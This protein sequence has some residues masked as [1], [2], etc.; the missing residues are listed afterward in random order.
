[1][2]GAKQIVPG[3][4]IA[5][6]RGGAQESQRGVPR[7]SGQRTSQRYSLANFRVARPTTI[8]NTRY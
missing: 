4:H 5:I 8:F 1:M 2:N 3:F 6:L 7:S